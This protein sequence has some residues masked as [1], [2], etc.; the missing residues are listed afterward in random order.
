[1]TVP[2]RTLNMYQGQD[3]TT[4]IEFVEADTGLPIDM[5]GRSARMQ[6]RTSIDAPE[7]VLSLSTDLGTIV[8]AGGVLRFQVPAMVT[9]MLGGHDVE[10]WVFDVELVTP[11]PTPSVRRILTGVIVFWPEI[12]RVE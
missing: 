12:T 11:G 2:F 6:A 3:F 4:E 9:A 5:T 7:A 8:L 1:M 10:Q